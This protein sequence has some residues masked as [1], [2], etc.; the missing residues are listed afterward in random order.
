MALRTIAKEEVGRMVSA[1]TAVALMEVVEASEEHGM[2]STLLW[3]WMMVR[4]RMCWTKMVRV[5]LGP[6][7]S[8]RT[9]GVVVVTDVGR[10]N[11][12]VL[13]MALWDCTAD[14]LYPWT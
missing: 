13:D 12:V 5:S 6:N 1:E 9:R 7:V 2:G 14:N 8:K 4:V 11:V 3:A 10:V